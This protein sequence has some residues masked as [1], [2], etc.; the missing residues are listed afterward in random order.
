MQPVLSSRTRLALVVFLATMPALIMILYTWQASERRALEQAQEN[1]VETLESATRSL[2]LLHET[3]LQLLRTIG[4]LPLADFGE[5]FGEGT[6]YSAYLS[7][8]LIRNSYYATIL[9]ADA[10]AQVFVA[11][12]DIEPYSLADRAYYQ[13]LTRSPRFLA[14]EV[15]MSRSTGHKVIPYVYPVL[16]DI[17]ALDYFLLAAFRLDRLPDVLELGRLHEAGVLEIFDRDGAPVFAGSA[18]GELPTHQWP[19]SRSFPLAADMLEGI[20]QMPVASQDIVHR[21]GQPYITAHA[22]LVSPDDP[23]PHLYLRY[24]IPVAAARANIRSIGVR[25]SGIMLAL[26]LLGAGAAWLYGNHQITRRVQLLVKATTEMKDGEFRRLQPEM[27]SGD[28]IGRL[29]ESFE[30][31][32]E[33]VV[34]REMELSRSAE[35]LR[36]LVA[37][38]EALMH[39]VHHRV[40]NNLQVVSSLLSLAQHEIGPEDA[41]TVLRDAHQRIESIAL[42]H[43][44][45]YEQGT[46]HRLSFRRYLESLSNQVRNSYIGSFQLL[47]VELLADDVELNLDMAIPIGLVVNEVLGQTL[48]CAEQTRQTATVKIT[49]RTS[50]ESE[51][52][53]LCMVVESPM[54]AQLGFLGSSSLSYQLLSTLALQI[55]AKL[56]IEGR[57][58]VVVQ[59]DSPLFTTGAPSVEEISR[60]TQ[61]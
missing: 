48:R 45:I 13:E 4:E 39:E 52:L 54:S 51:R 41:A 7:N 11:G 29:A 60:G 9:V 32:A 47:E 46:L 38:R 8:L 56:L 58:R 61:A 6:D 5:G 18:D 12:V 31:M 53:S 22:G 17:G 2:H 43:E 44:E 19:S 26:M 40:K 14:G 27:K 15:V 33:S 3:T 10:E 59:L 23:V 55:G 35:E 1:A 16:G 42:V 57:D 28:D 30:R 34:R 37:E 25:N 21:D 24:S 50:S 20:S 49:A 36:F